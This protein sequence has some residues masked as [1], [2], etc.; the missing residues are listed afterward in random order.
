MYPKGTKKNL[1][2]PEI[3]SLGEFHT[4]P[5]CALLLFSCDNQ[6][7]LDFLFFFF[8]LKTV[9]TVLNLFFFLHILISRG[10]GW[11]LRFPPSRSLPEIAMAY[12]GHCKHATKEKRR[13]RMVWSLVSSLCCTA[14]GPPLP[15]SDGGS[16]LFWRGR[17]PGT[18]FQ[19]F[20][21]SKSVRLIMFFWVTWSTL[22]H[23][24]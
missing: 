23:V 6:A 17:N 18:K 16:R 14:T 4:S 7:R 19:H 3:Y 11:F 2:R 21:F 22:L 9:K 5:P 15:L 10:R 8:L 24:C 13:G 12:I 1:K 20:F